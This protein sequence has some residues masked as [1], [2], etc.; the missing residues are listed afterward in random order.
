MLGNI[1]LA[2]LLL[3]SQYAAVSARSPSPL[4]RRVL[5]RSL[6]DA[7]STEWSLNVSTCPGEISH[8]QISGERFIGTLLAGYALHSMQNTKTGLSA[9]LSLAGPA[10][11]AFG[12]DIT[13]LTVD[14]TYE[15]ESR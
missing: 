11:N 14:V 7:A 9:Q 3:T 10:C 5:G 8:E 12:S 6:D 4:Q 13:N 2:T 1:L 15:S